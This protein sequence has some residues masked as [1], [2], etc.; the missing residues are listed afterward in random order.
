MK[1]KSPCLNCPDRT[2]GCHS[3]CDKYKQFQENLAEEKAL[4]YE[5]RRKESEYWSMRSHAK[6]R[7]IQA[8]KDYGRF[9]KS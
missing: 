7:S 8:R 2:I 5:A 9:K 6:H 1:S 4:A 3:A